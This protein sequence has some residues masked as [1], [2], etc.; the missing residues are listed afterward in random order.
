MLGNPTPPTP[1]KP[2]RPRDLAYERDAQNRKLRD[3]LNK[4]GQRHRQ[5]AKRR[6][7]PLARLTMDVLR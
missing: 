2:R 7:V 4:I 1:F 3:S 6:G 5:L